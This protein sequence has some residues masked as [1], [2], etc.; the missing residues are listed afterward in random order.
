MI[1]Y[2]LAIG[3]KN[4]AIIHSSFLSY[5]I[6]ILQMSSSSGIPAFSYDPILS[7]TEHCQKEGSKNKRIFLMQQPFS[8]QLIN[9]A[10]IAYTSSGII[11]VVKHQ[12]GGQI[13][14]PFTNDDIERK[15][16]ALKSAF[17]HL[18]ETNISTIMNGFGYNLSSRNILSIFASYGLCRST[19]DLSNLYDFIDI[20]RRISSLSCLTNQAHDSA[21]VKKVEKRYLAMRT[22]LTAKKGEKE[23]AIQSSGLQNSLFFYYWKSFKRYGFL[24]LVDKGKEV[25]RKSKIGIENEAKIV[26]DKIQY[27]D[28]NEN[29]YVDQLKTKGIKVDRSSIAKIFSKWEIKNY[30][31][32][33]IRNLNRLEKLS[34]SSTED[35]QSPRTDAIKRYV[36]ENFVD[37]IKRIGSQGIHVDGPGIFILWAYLEELGI[38]KKLSSM[39]LSRS[40]NDKGYNWVDLFLLN[41]GRIFYG[42]PTYS[43]TCSH[44]EPTL[45]FFSHLVNLPSNDSFLNGLRVISEEQLFDLQKWLVMKIKSLGLVKGEQLA[46]DFNQ[47]DFDLEC[48][49][50]RQHGN[51]PSSKKKNGYSGFRPHIAWDIDTN[52]LVI[53]EFRKSSAR[54]TTTVRRFVKDFLFETFKDTFQKVFVDSEYTGKDVWNFILDNDEGMGA[55]IT[56]CIKQ[57]PFVRKKRDAFLMENENDDKFWKHYDDNHVYSSKTFT[58]SWEYTNIKTHKNKIFTLYCVVKKCIKTEKLSCFATSNKNMNSYQ[59]LIAYSIRWKIENGIKDLIHNFYL[60][61][62]PGTQVQSANIHFFIVSL[63]KQLYQMIQRDLEDFVTNHDGTKTSLERMREVLF[64]QGSAKV[65]FKNNT[66][67]IQF[68]N[69]YTPKR[70]ELLSKFYQKITE[71]FP[72]GLK[73]L[74]GLKLKYSLKPPIR[75]GYGNG[76]KKIPISSLKFK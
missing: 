58:L 55:E 10:N 74:G 24:G 26:V 2:L 23:K 33:F 67:E 44:S 11:G 54:G 52:N 46:F 34:E 50:L 30:K 13:V 61:N 31:P 27:P 17:K 76:M 41:V 64:K 42:I 12:F 3:D 20:N 14:N 9:N 8:D 68:L 21:D 57:N 43:L 48:N 49:E 40:Q 72:D 6:D 5:I 71:R 28:R 35:K 1:A 53:L 60:Y 7:L 19:K 18:S 51:G 63:C 47:I 25:F 45:A 65:L 38:L 15:V 75:E 69:N 56:A 37:L 29:Y 16:I 36:D 22:Y 62:L 39:G 73:I 66:F 70:T 32:D 59:I 4:M